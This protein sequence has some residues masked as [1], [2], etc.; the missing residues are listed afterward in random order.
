MSAHV[1]HG[2]KS[3]SPERQALLAAQIHSNSENEM[4]LALTAL[5]QAKSNDAARTLLSAYRECH[6]RDTRI[7]ILR[8]LGR[9]GSERAVDFLL[10]AVNSED[11]GL[12]QEALLALGETKDPVA[13]TFLLNRLHS[14][15]MHLKPTIV[16]AIA[17]IPDLRAAPV[18]KEL[19]ESSE[20]SEHPQL[21]R[22]CVVALA[23]MKDTSILP[24]L[25]R[26]LRNRFQ[27]AS[28]SPD[29]T[30][31]TLLSAIA[32]LS[33]STSDLDDFERAFEGEMLHQQF[34]Q[35]SK[36]QI[37]FR[38]QWTLED[39]LGK[40]FFNEHSHRSLPLELN[41]F[42]AQDVI[43]ALS[44]FAAEEKHFRALCQVIS[45]LPDVETLCEKFIRIEQLNSDEVATFLKAIA[46]QR[47]EVVSRLAE[48]I[49]SVHIKQKIASED[50]SE[51]F[52]AWLRA[53]ICLDNDP[54]QRF[55]ELVNSDEYKKIWH[56]KNKVELINAFVSCALVVRN[57]KSWPKRL[58]QNIQEWLNQEDSAIVLGRWLRALGELDLSEIKWSDQLTDKVVQSKV[59]LASALHMLELMDDH[60]H[61][62]LL[63]GAQAQLDS[64]SEL[65][66]PFLRACAH[67]KSAEKDLPNDAL[68]KEALDKEQISH[69]IAALTCL[70]AHP[71]HPLLSRVTELCSPTHA[72]QQLTVAA[73]IAARSY[74]SEKTSPALTSCL[75]SPSKVL[76]GRALDALLAIDHPSARHSV[77]G[78]LLN[79]LSDAFITDKVLRSMKAPAQADLQAAMMLEE[80][81]KHSSS[82]VLKDD[83]LDLASR[84]R[85]GSAES[86]GS[87]P[88]SD[89]IKSLDKQLEI[90]IADYEK[91]ADPIKA[92]LR[93]AELPLNQPELFEGTVDK[94]SSVVQY[95]KAIDLA[96]EKEFGQKILFPKLEQQLHVFQ[97]IIHEAELDQDAPNMATVLRHL[98]AEHVFTP[99][100]FPMTK[101]LMIARSILSGRILR[102][103]TQLID[104][105][106]A[107]AVFL[108]LFSGK[109][110]LWGAEQLKKDP[111]VYQHL[112]QKLATLQDL[113]NP[114]AHRQTM[115]ALAPLSEIRKEVFNVFASMKKAF[116]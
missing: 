6:W 75:E 14:A 76:A 105:L 54:L 95:C 91:L 53:C 94:S 62:H 107:W 69:Q 40:I 22:N 29:A 101:T 99:H 73:I 32:K 102:E 17:R 12:C 10:R 104:G 3:L 71:R 30:S 5:E 65:R 113:R 2:S 86:T 85:S 109:D 66:A 41:S 79:H 25:L 106:K 100:T 45:A 83:L 81:L 74:K 37:S 51:I 116:S 58:L 27:H 97:N 68:L 36:T 108:L 114:A 112:A 26:M 34:F 89:I 111:L 20:S 84:L 56:E 47:G 96:L 78:F 55:T 24:Q 77:I 11:I 35:Q 57:E 67:L 63:K 87:I 48:Q 18:L 82:L 93:S 31:L 110:R 8:A 15:P 70:A 50:A 92:S 80:G 49:F 88:G 103:R 98:R 38:Q 64:F 9:N 61:S 28:T 7:K 43:E 59:L 33:R 46:L 21:L 13:A 90:K 72:Q 1:K 23:E 4:R 52:S 115:L 42:P 39:Y 19:I 16:S 44:L 60:T